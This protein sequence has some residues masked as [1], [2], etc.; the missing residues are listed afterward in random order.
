MDQELLVNILCDDC[1][2]ERNVSLPMRGPTEVQASAPWILTHMVIYECDCG[3]L[4]N[5]SLLGYFTLVRGEGPKNVRK[6]APCNSP[7]EEPMYLAGV[8]EDGLLRLKCAACD[9]ERTVAR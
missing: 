1:F 8:L 5:P 2:Y 4:Y 3:R 9:Y 6:L 7:R